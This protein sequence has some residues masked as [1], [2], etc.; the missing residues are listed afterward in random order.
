MAEGAALSTETADVTLL[1][2]NLEKMEYSIRMGRRVTSKIVQNVIFSVVVKFVVLGF[3]LSGK[4]QLWA[5]I[6]S[7]VGAMLVVTLNA[8]ALLPRQSRESAKPSPW[9]TAGHDVEDG[10]GALPCCNS[11]QSDCRI[12]SQDQECK[13]SIGACPDGAGNCRDS[14]KIGANVSVVQD[15]GYPVLKPCSKVQLHQNGDN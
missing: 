13:R 1:D 4:T 12:G 3:A 8:M 2:S 11:K 6:G 7:D 5:A 10:Q 15:V 14:A 9:N